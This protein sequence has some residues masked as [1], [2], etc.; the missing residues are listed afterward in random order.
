MKVKVNNSH[1]KWFETKTGV[2]QEDPLSTLLFS[3]VLYSV[4]TNLEVQGNLTTRLKQICAYAD[5]IIIIGRT[6]QILIDTFC[7]LKHEALNAGLIVN[8][9]KTKYLYCTRKIIHPI[10]IKTGE[11]QFEQAN[12]FKYLG[13]IVNTDNSIE[14]EIKEI[15]AAGNRTYHVHKKLFS[16]K[17]ISQNVK[18]QLYNTLI[19]QTVTYASETW[20]LKE[21]VTNKLMTFERKI[22]RKIFGPK[23]TNDG[24]WRIKTNQEINDILGQNIIGFIKKKRLN[25][26]GHVEH[27]AEDNIVQKI[28]R[29]K[30]RS[31]RPIGIPKTRWED[32]VLED[33]KS[34]NVRNWKKVAQNRDS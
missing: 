33:I 7:K 34:I 27:M 8:N 19:C 32:E 2:T 15:T 18:L 1:S 31:K 17:L 20:V 30:L 14:E 28:K 6:K 24:Y 4:I 11:E 12:S 16:S 23:G 10:Y 25:W 21:H 9:N 5:D 29:W 22:M 26:L 3:V 13:T